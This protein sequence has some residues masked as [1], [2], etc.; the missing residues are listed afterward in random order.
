[1]EAQRSPDVR[2][3]VRTINV[4]RAFGLITNSLE[5]TICVT[6]SHI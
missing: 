2:P 4:P 5:G 6:A 3:V 1:L